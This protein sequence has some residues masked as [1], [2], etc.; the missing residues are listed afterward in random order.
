[1]CAPARALIDVPRRVRGGRGCE[2]DRLGAGLVESGYTQYRLVELSYSHARAR[3][4]TH[5]SVNTAAEPSPEG[6]IGMG[7]R[8]LRS[9]AV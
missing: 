5:T 3:A 4:L 7:C 2:R 9:T 6:N 1:M 8:G